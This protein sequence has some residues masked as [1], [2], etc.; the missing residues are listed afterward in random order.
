[1]FKTQ[2][3]F[4]LKTK[5]LGLNRTNARMASRWILSGIHQLNSCSLNTRLI[6]HITSQW[7]SAFCLFDINYSSLEMNKDRRDPRSR[8]RQKKN[9]SSIRQRAEQKNRSYAQ[10]TPKQINL[11]V[12]FD[13]EKKS[14]KFWF[15]FII[16]SMKKKIKFEYQKEKFSEIIHDFFLSCW[17]LIFLLQ[18]MSLSG[19]EKNITSVSSSVYRTEVEIVKGDSKFFLLPNFIRLSLSLWWWFT[20]LSRSREANRCLF[21]LE[22]LDRKFVICKS[23][24]LPWEN[25]IVR[26]EKHQQV[27]CRSLIEGELQVST[28]NSRI[29]SPRHMIMEDDMRFKST[30]KG[31]SSGNSN[32]YYRPEEELCRASR[33]DWAKRWN[34]ILSSVEKCLSRE[35]CKFPRWNNKLRF[36]VC[37]WWAAILGVS[38]ASNRSTDCGTINILSWFNRN[39]ELRIE[40]INLYGGINSRLSNSIKIFELAHCMWTWVKDS[41]VS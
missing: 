35:I 30:K 10:S 28:L 29:N 39:A 16:S 1:M 37:G 18:L 4:L 17:N 12:A 14:S 7:V 21:V 41:N 31:E 22:H 13:E 8:R 34:T 6:F 36:F 19:D 25:W 3:R 15:Q 33:V 24:M 9:P 38:T 40:I 20:M 11:R 2:L 5:S 23:W 27:N 32:D 26:C